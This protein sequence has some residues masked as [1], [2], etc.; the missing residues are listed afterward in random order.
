MGIGDD[1]L[2]VFLSF[3][4]RLLS[5]EFEVGV[6]PLARWLVRRAARQL[7]EPVRERYEAQWLQDLEDME[8]PVGQLVNATSIWWLSGSIARECLTPALAHDQVRKIAPLVSIT[9][10]GAK[11]RVGG[12]RIRDD[13]RGGGDLNR[14]RH[15]DHPGDWTLEET[16]QLLLTASVITT[17]ASA[18]ANPTRRRTVMFEIPTDGWT[19]FQTT[20]DGR[21]RGAAPVKGAEFT[22][23]LTYEDRELV[24]GAVAERTSTD[25]VLRDSRVY[26]Y[27]DGSKLVME[28][29]LDKASE[30]IQMHLNHEALLSE[31]KV[32]LGADMDLRKPKVMTSFRMGP[33]GGAA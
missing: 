14:Y 31:G 12:L 30:N 4:G 25:N 29:V 19:V 13:L 27:T 20:P 2:A 33:G 23:H 3:L 17:V 8:S 22:L 28:L 24:L 9:T 11:V 21:L 1:V 32:I 18:T 6:L 10:V 16:L 15:P 5:K 26:T 7:P